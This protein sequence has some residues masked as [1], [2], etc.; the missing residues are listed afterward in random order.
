MPKKVGAGG[1]GETANWKARK[2]KN[3]TQYSTSGAD[4]TRA[5]TDRQVQ[6]GAATVA[7]GV[8]GGRGGGGLEDGA[9]QDVPQEASEAVALRGRL[10]WDAAG[11]SGGPEKIS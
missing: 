1:R 6:A 8:C 10:L 11:N 2:N 3:S 5:E 4:A 7:L 9:A